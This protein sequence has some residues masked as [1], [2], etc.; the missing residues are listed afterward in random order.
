MQSGSLAF[1]MRGSVPLDRLLTEIRALFTV[2][3]GAVFQVDE[4]YLDTFDWRMYRNGLVFRQSGTRFLLIPLD[5]GPVQETPGPLKTKLFWRDFAEDGV[6]ERLAA[7]TGVRAIC[8]LVRVVGQR[9]RFGIS[10]QDT[11]TV[12]RLTLDTGDVYDGSEG[13]GAF[14]PYLFLQEIRGYQKPFHRLSEL[15]RNQGWRQ[16]EAGENFIGLA[17]KVINRQPADYSSKILAAPRPD[18][19]MNQAISM[20]GLALHAAMERNLPGVLKDIDPEFLHDFRVALRRTRSILSQLKNDIPPGKA[21][22]FQTE[23][24]WLGSVT[25][26]VRDIDV[27]QQKEENFRSMLAGTLQQGLAPLLEKMQKPR[28]LEWKKMRDSLRSARA[29]R[30]LDN[31]RDFLTALPTDQWPAGE[32]LCAE[33]ATKV[34]RKCYRRLMRDASQ[35]RDQDDQDAAM[36]RLRIQAKKFRY[37]SE[38]F[39]L[40]FPAA[41]MDALLEDM[42]GI[43]DI[44]GEFHDMAVQIRGFELFRESSQ[45]GKIDQETIEGLLVGLEAEKKRM[46]KKCLKSCITFLEQREQQVLGGV[47]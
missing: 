8:P 27:C 3:E 9:R 22:Y 39:R 1:T 5:G 41:D 11:K 10:N 16:L 35:I 14:D 2:Q 12:A 33:A 29:V 24:K 30:L 47:V 26:P 25:G 42:R 28:R 37:L 6:P 38:F 18:Q 17:L 23:F 20:V 13:R 36:H 21:G 45:S 19:T 40:C 31:W 32:V 7:I 44:L 43:Q 46:R 34:V 15:I 4:Q